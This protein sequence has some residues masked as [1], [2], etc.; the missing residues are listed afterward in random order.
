MGEGGDRCFKN[1]RNIGKGN[2]E[3]IYFGNAIAFRL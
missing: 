2:V 3:L 1:S